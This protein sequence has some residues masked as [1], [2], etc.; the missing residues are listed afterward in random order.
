LVI[1]VYNSEKE[2]SQMRFLSRLV[3]AFVVCL[4]AVVLLAVPAQAQGADIIL[5][6]SSGVPGEEVR[7]RGYNF[8]DDAWVDIYYYPNGARIRV[9][10][11]ETDDDGDFSWVTFIVPES[12]TGVHEVYA[13]DDDEIDADADFTVEPGLIVDPEEGPVGTNVTVEG[14]G[15]ADEEEEIEL[16]YYTDGDYVVVEDDITADDD[17]SWEVS[18]QIPPSAQGSHELD[19]DGDENQYYEV[20]NAAFEVTPKISLDKSSGSV[21][22]NITMRGSGF[23]ADDRDITILFDGEAV[24]AEIRAND[25]GS[26]NGSFEVPEMPIGEYSVTAEG[27]QTQDVSELTFKIEPEIVLSPAQGHVGTELTVTGRGFAT[28]EYVSIMYDG[29]QVATDKTNAEGSFDVSFTVPESKHGERL[30]TVEDDADNEATAIF[31]MES[32]PPDTPELSSP[33][34]GGRVGFIGSVRPTVEWS[35]VSDDSGVYYSLQIAV[36]ANFNTTEEFVDPIFSVDGLVGTNYTLKET[37]ALPYGT[38]YW[39]VQAVDGA[40]NESGWTEAHSFRSGLL[41]LWAFIVIIV[42]VVVLIG[43]LVYFF[44][45]RKRV[46]YY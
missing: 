45:I 9:A 23:E 26:W 31:T 42:V 34:D 21:G 6:P 12:C 2:V 22:D 36:S 32:D 20:K 11:V 28:D 3:I 4:V 33:P 17:G 5:S 40:D 27:E 19:A 10:E 46:R 8:T 37:E 44:V 14:R 39:I 29:S 35:E 24:R 1:F 43:T 18:F 25:M 30:V 16:R 15:F 13:E 41:P 38:Y 7:V